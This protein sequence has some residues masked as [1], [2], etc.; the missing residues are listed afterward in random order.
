MT[1]VR[2]TYPLTSAAST[3]ASTN[4]S[5]VKSQN[6]FDNTLTDQSICLEKQSQ[7]Q[8]EQSLRLLNRLARS[9]DTSTSTATTAFLKVELN[10]NTLEEDTV[11]HGH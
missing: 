10:W 7:V 2:Q 3:T 5:T 8:T 9:F 6:T 4:G 1:A 11:D